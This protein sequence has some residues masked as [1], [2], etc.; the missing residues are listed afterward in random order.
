VLRDVFLAS[1]FVAYVE[2]KLFFRF[3]T[4]KFS[5]A[6]PN[7]EDDGNMLSLLLP[8]LRA[9]F[10]SMGN[11]TLVVLP[12]KRRKKLNGNKNA[13][14]APFARC[15]GGLD[16]RG[17]Y[18]HCSKLVYRS[19]LTCSFKM[20]TSVLGNHGSLLERDYLI[21]IAVAGGGCGSGRS[22]PTNVL[23]RFAQAHRFWHNDTWICLSIV[24]CKALLPAHKELMETGT[25]MPVVDRLDE[26]VLEGEGGSLAKV[27]LLYPQKVFWGDNLKGIVIHYVPHKATSTG[28]DDCVSN[29]LNSFDEV[30]ELCAESNE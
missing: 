23:V 26:I 22:Y 16:W 27:S 18:E 28:N 4:G 20:A 25:A 7:K 11:N 29:R 17:E 5:S 14:M 21:L 3:C 10:S 19:R 2:P 30:K 15:F 12:G 9:Q 13:K 24:A 1:I 8:E 6:A